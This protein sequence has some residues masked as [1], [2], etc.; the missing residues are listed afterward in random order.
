[1]KDPNLDGTGERTIE[2]SGLRIAS[3]MLGLLGLVIGLL[4]PASSSRVSEDVMFWIGGTAAAVGLC[5][6]IVAL[7]NIKRTHA[8][9]GLPVAGTI[10]SALTLIC[11]LP[12]LLN[13]GGR[14]KEIICLNH[15]AQLRCAFEMY[16]DDNGGKL[17][18]AGH[19]CDA[20]LTNYCDGAARLFV[21]PSDRASVV[22]CSYVYNRSMS[23]KPWSNDVPVVVLFEVC[24]AGWNAS[25]GPEVFGKNSPH[26][27][28]CN[29]LFSDRH[30]EWISWSRS[31]ELKWVSSPATSAPAK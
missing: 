10:V 2:S 9:K 22:R 20:I 17:P 15:L 24:D 1:M 8:G 13:P 28:G 31:D 12:A 7:K 26:K 18:D 3:L 4:S 5:M 21:C 14:P 30:V 29:V 6:G 11:W 16:A 23:S 27:G 25:G 19:W